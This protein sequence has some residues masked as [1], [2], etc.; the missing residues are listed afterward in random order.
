MQQKHI[1]LTGGG[2]AGHVT[3]N[4]AIISKL[5]EQGWKISYIGS[6][7]GIEKELIT[8]L[9]IPYYPISTGKLRRYF[10]WQNFLDPLKI[11]FGIWQAF[12]LCHK[13]KPDI[14]FSK[15]G[16]VSFPVVIS[17]WLLRI[18]VILHESDFSPG[19]ANK[20]SFPFAGK[21]CLTFADSIKYFHNKNKDKIVV[22]GTPI[23][24]SLLHGN[25]LKGLDLCHFTKDKKVILVFGGSLGAENINKIIRQALPELIKNSHLQ[26]I[27]V[28]GPGKIDPNIIYPEYKQFSYLDEDFSHIIAAADIVICRSG[29]NSVYELLALQKPHIFIPLAKNSSRGDQ[30][31]NALHFAKKGISQVILDENLNQDTLID[32]IKWLIDNQ[33]NVINKINTLN[34]PD[35]TKII[36]ELITTTS[37]N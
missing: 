28:C 10:S 34:L 30:I 26:I 1:L 6:A 23:R 29:A 32:K 35:S 9:N 24:E 33:Q 14:I 36:C 12:W 37:K 13:L 31:D 4:I 11:I 17:G 19:L 20:L 5:R 25:S 22:T 27:H 16:F 8:K 3:P 21:I 15:G 18:P 7:Q 2:S